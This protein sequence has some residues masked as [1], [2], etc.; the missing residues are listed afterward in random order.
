M[1]LHNW[2]QTL[3]SFWQVVPKDYVKYLPHALS[4]E[5]EQARA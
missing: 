3:G 4:D 1:L 2:Q 5:Q